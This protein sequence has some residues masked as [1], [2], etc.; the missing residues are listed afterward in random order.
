MTT[1]NEPKSVTTARYLLWLAEGEPDGGEPVTHLRLQKLLYYAQGW[2]LAATGQPLF[3]EEL[4]AWEHGPVAVLAY[5]HFADYGR[6]PI[7]PHEA[8]A[9]EEL[10]EG[11]RNLLQSVWGHYKQF[12][13]SG[14]RAMTHREPP[15]IS[16]RAGAADASPSR[17]PI[18]RESM[19]DHFRALYSK[20]A[21]RWDGLSI[22]EFEQAEEQHEQDLGV[23]LRDKFPGLRRAV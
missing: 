16:A 22:D 20:R 12:S 23:L 1:G 6:D 5:P 19:T 14:L 11:E 17:R 7:A 3:D 18:S 21:D 10:S 4:Q 15:Y 8:S 9:A 2:S 13:A